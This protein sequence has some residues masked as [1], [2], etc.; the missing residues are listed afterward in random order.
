MS[1]HRERKAT[2][3]A[4]LLSDARPALEGPPFALGELVNSIVSRLS[5]ESHG[6]YRHDKTEQ[7]DHA[8]NSENDS[9][10]YPKRA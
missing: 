4:P 1:P 6:D 9:R 5:V 8:K 10:R 7:Q 3:A 2:A